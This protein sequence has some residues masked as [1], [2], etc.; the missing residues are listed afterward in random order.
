M[1]RDL[2]FC[3]LSCPYNKE[4]FCPLKYGELSDEQKKDNEP[5]KP[6]KEFERS[7]LE[8]IRPRSF[9]PGDNGGN[10]TYMSFTGTINISPYSEYGN[11][12][13][14]G[15]MIDLYL[16]EFSL[17]LKIE[18]ENSDNSESSNSN[19]NITGNGMFNLN[20]DE[21]FGGL[22]EYVFGGVSYTGSFSC[23]YKGGS[24]SKTY[25]GEIIINNIIGK[26]T[27]VTDM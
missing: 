27:I 12:Q 6:N 13:I 9:T 11:I 2:E 7:N 10:N 23:N 20:T 8:D 14:S 5:S 3:G 19:I 22:I 4:K 18:N 26:I 25:S 17:S 24:G 15:R 16:G 1:A 21:I